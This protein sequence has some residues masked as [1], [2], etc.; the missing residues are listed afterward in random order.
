MLEADATLL[1]IKYAARH[2]RAQG[3]DIDYLSSQ[4]IAS[5]ATSAT[6]VDHTGQLRLAVT[7]AYNAA[8]VDVSVTRS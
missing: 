5:D 7:I 1:H 6:E 2:M 8:Q 4:R 3:R